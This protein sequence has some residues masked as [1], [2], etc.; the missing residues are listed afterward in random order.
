MSIQYNVLE[1][2]QYCIIK[3]SR[4]LIIARYKV[5]MGLGVKLGLGI[6]LVVK[7]GYGC[8]GRVGSRGKVGFRGRIGVWLRGR[9]RD[10]LH[11]SRHHTILHF[12]LGSSQY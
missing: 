9:V 2:A 8:R 1:V 10:D 3:F 5:W 6:G 4:W 11:N 7:A 12:P